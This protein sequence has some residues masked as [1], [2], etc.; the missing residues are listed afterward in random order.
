MEEVSLLGFLSLSLLFGVMR[1]EE[2]LGIYYPGWGGA[3]GG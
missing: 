1:S 2:I 3:G